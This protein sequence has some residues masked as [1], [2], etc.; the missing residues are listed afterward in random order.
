MPPKN[1]PAAR[2]A[3]VPF[4]S[5]AQLLVSIVMMSITIV[6][7]ARVALGRTQPPVWQALVIAATANLLGKVMVSGLHLPG[8]VSYSL[9]TL[10]FLV[11]SVLFFKPTPLRLVLYW[12]VG[13]AAYLALH[14]VL[15]VALGWTFMFPF[16]RLA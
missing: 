3:V 12:A 15:A 11:L 8:L 6:I 5:L 7:G 14:V 16:W 10:A 1:T 4:A 9:P 13:L 2:E